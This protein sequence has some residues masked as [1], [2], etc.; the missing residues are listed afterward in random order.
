M[1]KFLTSTIKV[2]AVIA[3]ILLL[4]FNLIYISQV[5]NT[6]EQVKI[7]LVS[8]KTHALTILTILVLLM[9]LFLN[10]KYKIIN[11]QNK[12]IIIILLIIYALICYKWINYSATTPV[13]DSKMVYNIARNIII[14]GLDYAKNNNYLEKCP[15]QITMVLFFA[16]IMRIFS[17]TDFL[18]FQL[19]NIVANIFII[20]GIYKITNMLLKKED[21]DNFISL[22]LTITFFPL[23]IICNF[24]YGDYLGLALAIW[25]LIFLFKYNENRKI[26]FLMFSAILLLCAIVIKTNYLIFLI[27]YII[28]FMVNSGNK[29][30][31]KNQWLLKIGLIIVYVAISFAP[32]YAIKEYTINRLKLDK[33]ESLPTSA[34]LYMEMSESYRE[35]GWYGDVILDAWDKAKESRKK[36]PKLIQKRIEYFIDNPIDFLDFYRRKLTSGWADPTF[37]SI[38]YGIKQENKATHLQNIF[39]STKYQMVIIYTRALMIIIY[40]FSLFSLIYNWKRIKEQTLLL[41]IIF[42]G[43]VFFHLLWEMKARYT[44]PYIIILIPLATIGLISLF[45]I[46]N[47]KEK[48]KRVL[49]NNKTIKIP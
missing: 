49:P 23:I 47:N 14:N 36:Y 32:Y 16:M 8:I 9:T 26:V 24:V 4:I 20:L 42:L 12:K 27:A 7:S 5:I 6:I 48:I 29:Q 43:G 40:G 37:Q 21:T 18:V 30:K 34:Y 19:L 38:W 13:D 35:A 17:T 11:L 46:I 41:Y 3:L 15:Q 10:R 33:Q 28:Y 44:M 25:S 39:N 31:H 45:N 1:D 2:I 22:F